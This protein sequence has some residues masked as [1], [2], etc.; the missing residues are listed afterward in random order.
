M[1]LQDPEYLWALVL[2]PLLWWL[3]RP[4]A[5]RRRLLTAHFPQWQSA[6]RA[7]RRRAPR[8]SFL[9][10]VLLAIAMVG[11]V[12]AAAGVQT[13]PTPG[14]DRLVVLL[15]ASRSMAAQRDG[16]SAFARARAA[17]LARLA[18]VPAHVEVVLL[19][20]GGDLRRRYGESARQLTDL[21]EPGGALAVDLA[22]L[23]ESLRDARTQV[24]VYTDGQGQ[25]RLPK[26]GALDVY[27]ARGDNVSIVD[28]RLEDGWPLPELQIAVDLVVHAAADADVAV[29]VRGAIEG[30]QERR[31][32]TWRDSQVITVNLGL[33]R[34]A[35]GGDVELR[36]VLADDVL[37]GDDVR[38]LRLPPLPAPRI[39]VL[40]DSDAGPFAPV[41][42]EALADE[43]KGHVVPAT[44]GGEVGLLIVD[45][46]VAE[47]E[48]GSARAITFGARLAGQLDP[49]PWLA[50]AGID[51]DREHVLTRGLDLSELQVDRAWRGVLPD[52]QPI[53]WSEEGGLRAPLAVLSQ[54]DGVASIH[55]AFR[56]QD[57]NLPLL[58]AFPQLLRRGF[59]RSYDA[60]ASLTIE[61]AAPPAG[62]LDLRYAQLATSRPG[63][64]FGQPTRSLARWFVAAGLL[65]LGFRAFMR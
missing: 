52:G 3:S 28:V 30:E 11:A 34:A 4:P 44:A 64:A 42:A 38:V 18:A 40:A 15:D 7:Q 53:L 36:A 41:A 32:V 21:G 12:F 61:G 25:V 20:C 9:R 35:I 43:V 1:S 50:P 13:A 60:A 23:A 22:E 65:A 63:S 33:R 55:F 10:F 56:L 37:C 47:L 17:L 45:G 39:A 57:S 14:P 6:M 19:R 54:G 26:Y 5:P 49:E 8:G 2:L 59:V 46:G 58:A 27:D 29:V 24:W 51:W 48:P 62:E 31:V 16:V